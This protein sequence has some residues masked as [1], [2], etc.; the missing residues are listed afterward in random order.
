MEEPQ[1][2]EPQGTGIPKPQTEEPQGTGDFQKTEDSQEEKKEL[3]RREEIKTMSKD[4][5]QLREIEAQKEKERLIALKNQEPVQPIQT[6]QEET[7]KPEEEQPAAFIPPLPEEFSS[8]KKVFV[9]IAIIAIILLLVGGFFYW[10]LVIK[11]QSAPEITEQL[12]IVPTSTAPEIPAEIII[13]P[14]L[15]EVQSTFTIEA[16]SSEDVPLLMSQFLKTK[17]ATSSG[18]ARILIK[19]TKENKLL[20][21]SDFF[22]VFKITA[23]PGLLDKLSNDFTLFVYSNNGLN[24][25][26]FL[27]EIKDK[28]NIYNTGKSW[29][30]TM[31]KNTENFF[32]FL[33]NGK[34]SH[35]LSFRQAYYKKVPFRYFSFST[36]KFGICWSTYDYFIWTTSGESMLRIIDVLLK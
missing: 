9:R 6:K 28:E 34:T 26:G 29:E 25:L 4:I 24:R 21:L 19:N 30:P 13:P 16:T 3:L 7:L 23:P 8:P 17:M 2:G 11:K 1:T 32:A 33:G 20:G 10:Y 18:F 35:P 15:I 36:N 31:E 12:S 5:S 27:T 14:S 22:S